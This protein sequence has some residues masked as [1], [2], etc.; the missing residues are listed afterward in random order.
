MSIYDIYI[1][2]WR[3]RDDWEGLSRW[4]EFTVISISKAS[5][6]EVVL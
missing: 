1:K 3:E 6:G 2:R 5:W 4:F